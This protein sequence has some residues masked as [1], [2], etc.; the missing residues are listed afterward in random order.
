[1]EELNMS[2]TDQIVATL[3]EQKVK[4]SIVKITKNALN[5]S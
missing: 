1:M 2:K 3:L 4:A 5:Y